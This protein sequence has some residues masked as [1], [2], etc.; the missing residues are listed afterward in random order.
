MRLS[1]VVPA[2]LATPWWAALLLLFAVG[3][4]RADLI[5]WS[6]SWSNTPAKIMADKPGTG[7]IQLTNQSTTPVVGNS[8]IV[9][10]NL[11]TFSTASAATP[12]VFT[13]APYTLQM[14][15][16]DGTSDKSNILTFMGQFDGTL[17][18]ASTDLTATPTASSSNLTATLSTATTEQFVLGNNLYT[19]TIGPYSPPGPPDTGGNQGSISASATVTVQPIFEGLPEPGTLTLSCLG[20]ASLG[21]ARW[22]RRRWRTGRQRVGSERET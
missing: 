11:T 10:T 12:D 21:L 7:Y 2:V 19:V 17:T 6:Y 18:G 14:T 8:Y 4:A 16:T 5:H 3:E 13:A 15:I 9:A 1:R 20:A 22:R